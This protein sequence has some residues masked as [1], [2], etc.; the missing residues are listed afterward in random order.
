M[1]RRGRPPQPLT[2]RIARGNPGKQSTEQGTA[3]L[4]E[5][6]V[7]Q[8]SP[9]CPLWLDD[10]ARA[11]WNRVVHQLAAM[12]IVA[13]V[14]EDVLAM[15]CNTA[16]EYVACAV[17]LRKDGMSLKEPL[18]NK[19]KEIIGERTILHPLV[20]V[21]KAL[22]D[23]L[24]AVSREIGT[25]PKARQLLHVVMPNDEAEDLELFLADDADLTP[26][27]LQKKRMLEFC[28]EHPNAKSHR[29]SH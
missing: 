1:G 23:Q 17:Q 16:A 11:V 18:L 6:N 7:G 28:A 15:L 2:Q 14:D 4:E 10:A 8:P 12:G 22:A 25:T 13:R 29:R 20:R 21:K 24:L 27:Q 26:A 9:E 19:H 5:L 3:T